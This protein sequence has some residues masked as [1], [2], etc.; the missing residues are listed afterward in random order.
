MEKRVRILL[1]QVSFLM[2]RYNS[3]HHDTGSSSSLLE[4]GIP[5][6]YA[7]TNRMWQQ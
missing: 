7:L 3:S 1:L 2:C 4:S 6:G 5:L